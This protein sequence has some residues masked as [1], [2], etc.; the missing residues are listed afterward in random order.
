VDVYRPGGEAI[1]AALT[2]SGYDAHFVMGGPAALRTVVDW[3]PDIALLDINMP[4]MDGCAVARRLRQDTLSQHT[5]IVA[6][7]ALDEAMARPDGVAPGFDA[8]CQK[9][10]APGPLLQLLTTLIL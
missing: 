6:I 4:D 5:I 8:Y 7:T 2:A 9:G 1:T 3:V 10:A